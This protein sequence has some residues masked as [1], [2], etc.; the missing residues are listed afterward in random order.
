MSFVKEAHKNTIEAYE[1]LGAIDS[2]DLS[3]AFIEVAEDPGDEET[4]G[5][6]AVVK[7][8]PDEEYY[9][10]FQGCWDETPLEAAQGLIDI[11]KE[12]GFIKK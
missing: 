5:F 6:S 10:Y 3:K 8:Y 2:D 4:E 9:M 12:E 11:L 7:V 1:L